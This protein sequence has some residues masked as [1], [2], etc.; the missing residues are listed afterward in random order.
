LWPFP[1]G[2]E[3]ELLQAKK[4]L[5]VENNSTGQLAGLIRRETGIATQSVLKDD[6]RPFFY[7]EIAEILRDKL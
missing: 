1:S 7:D 2:L 5:V 6:G 3:S 4:I